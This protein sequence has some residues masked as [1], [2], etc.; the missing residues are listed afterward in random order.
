[1]N[2]SQELFIKGSRLTV[3]M[4]TRGTRCETKDFLD[5]CEKDARSAYVTLFAR[6]R[7]L[8]E[9][10]YIRNEQQFKQ[11]RQNLFE[12]KESGGARLFGFFDPTNRQFFLLTHGW[13]KGPA[14]EQTQQIERAV[15][16]RDAYLAFR[17]EKAAQK[18]K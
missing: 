9:S 10:G 16:M 7:Y 5:D 12:V 17:A 13:K 15:R 11:V 3:C 6:I 2:W 14:K 4:I 18:R 1:M 8:A